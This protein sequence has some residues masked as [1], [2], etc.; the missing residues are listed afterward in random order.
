MWLVFLLAKGGERIYPLLLF[1][2]WSQGF[3]LIA[4]QNNRY[5]SVTWI[6]T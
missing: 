1:P 3:T 4:M 2:S 5:H 6:Y